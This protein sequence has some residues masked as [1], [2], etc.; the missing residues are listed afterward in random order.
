M[1]N[2]LL[3]PFK[4]TIQTRSPQSRRHMLRRVQPQ[5]SEPFSPQETAQ[6][7]RLQRTSLKDLAEESNRFR[8]ER[9]KMCQS[10]QEVTDRYELSRSAF[11]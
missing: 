1:H 2:S 5:A 10:E 4:E 11:L 3:P 6:L 7:N 8:R 9:E